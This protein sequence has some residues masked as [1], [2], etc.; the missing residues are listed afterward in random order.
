VTIV[1][2]KKPRTNSAVK[3]KQKF[4]MSKLIPKQIA[5]RRFAAI[6]QA[7]PFKGPHVVLI[8]GN[9]ALKNL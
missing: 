1:I 4:G 9:Q 5:E 7:T 6:S 2:L 8:N 3:G